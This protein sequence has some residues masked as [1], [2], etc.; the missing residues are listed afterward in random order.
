VLGLFPTAGLELSATGE[1]RRGPWALALELSFQTTGGWAVTGGEVRAR[2][3]SVRLAVSYHVSA[4]RFELA[5]HI[6]AG[7]GA[8]QV[9][10]FGFVSCDCQILAPLI[11]IRAGAHFAAHLVGSFWLD[12]GGDLGLL[13]LRYQY[14]VRSHPGG[15]LQTLY[16]APPAFGVVQLGLSL[17]IG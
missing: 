9:T 12:L 5:P 1:A 8:A 17:H 6:A 7:G 14:G 13:P 4:G 15:Q 11:D 16:A 3:G 10:A 2:V